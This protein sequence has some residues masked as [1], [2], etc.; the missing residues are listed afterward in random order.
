MDRC[1]IIVSRD[2]PNLFQHLSE[3]QSPD[4]EVILD[5]RQAPRPPSRTGGQWHTTLERDGYVVV[6]TT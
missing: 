5:R 6:P 3:R 2:R 1:L 4:V